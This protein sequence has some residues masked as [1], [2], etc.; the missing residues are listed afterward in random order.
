MSHNGIDIDQYILL[1]VY[2]SIAFFVIG[3]ITK[4]KNIKKS[5]T[6]IIQSIICF[7]FSTTYYIFVPHG[8]AQGLSLILGLFGILLLILARKEKIKP[9]EENENEN[10]QKNSSSSSSS[11]G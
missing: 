3:Y 10:K 6:Y 9:E 5:I 11:S 7:I 4:K 2:P 8:G 1:I